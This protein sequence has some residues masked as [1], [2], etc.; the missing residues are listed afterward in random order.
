MGEI[1]NSQLNND[2]DGIIGNLTN[3]HYISG[4]D[5]IGENL[6]A[7]DTELNRVDTKVGS[8]SLITHATDVS[9]AINELVTDINTTNSNVGDVSK[10]ETVARD[11]VSAV[12][13][14]KNSAVDVSDLVDALN[15]EVNALSDKVGTSVLDIGHDLSDAVND[16]KSLIDDLSAEISSITV[17]MYIS[18]DGISIVQDGDKYKI[19]CD[20][21]SYTQ[22]VPSYATGSYNIGTITINGTDYSIYGVNTSPSLS[23][24]GITVDS[25]EINTLSGVDKSRTLQSQ[26][27]DIRN[28][29]Q[30]YATV[31]Q[32]NQ[33]LDKSALSLDGTTLIV[34]NP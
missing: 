26:I 2:T 25:S 20:S 33:K 9:E 34:N 6:S 13:E 17:P 30:N 29:L 8:V 3:G 14:V 21:V 10:L 11:L 22:A 19:N 4:N 5:T 16:L 18:G 31:A 27:N 15:T 28:S 1:F 24:F 7:L 12:N 32:L 23:S